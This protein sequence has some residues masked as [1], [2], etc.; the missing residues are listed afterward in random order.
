MAILTRKPLETE[1]E[2]RRRLLFLSISQP[3]RPTP[4]SIDSP[5]AL[6]DNSPLVRQ[7]EPLNYIPPPPY[8]VFN[9]K[10]RPIGAE[11]GFDQL[12]RN[13]TLLEA[14]QGYQ[15]KGSTKNLLLSMGLGFLRG[16]LPGVAA[17]GL[18]YALD[19]AAIDRAQMERAMGQTQGAIETDLTRRHVDSQ[20]A[21]QQARLEALKRKP[22]ED[23]AKV[24]EQERDNLRQ[25]YNAQPYF[26]P[27]R[28]PQHKAIAER[29]ATLNMTLPSRDEKDDSQLEWVNGSLQRVS[30]SGR[31]PVTAATDASGQPLV[32][33]TDVPVIEDGLPVTPGQALNYRGMIGR[34]AQ[35]RSDKAGQS[36]QERQ[37]HLI[38]RDSA[39]NRAEGF[40]K[41]LTDIDA[42]LS[43]TLSSEPVLKD[44]VPVTDEKGNIL[45]GNQTSDRRRELLQR[46]DAVQRDYESAIDEANKETKLAESV[47]VP[48]T[49][50]SLQREDPK[51]R[52]YADRF[53]G[54]DYQ[55]A[56][57]AIRKQRGQ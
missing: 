2:R 3:P 45:Y 28:N 5:T 17:S 50:G 11:G 46:R 40:K 30:R 47:Y 15:P 52:A 54:G 53:F 48:P 39:A 41:Q 13:Q 32:R 26:D 55:A 18:S 16:G 36:T 4:T 49:G 34:E 35:Q 22:L 1:E 33:Q 8:P 25:I 19:P 27:E 44:G 12:S 20:M 10:G 57:S 7:P 9:N 14:Q 21:E 42:E 29:A 43:R 38:A 37:A 6:P 23:A 31:R 24:M 56:Q 51:V